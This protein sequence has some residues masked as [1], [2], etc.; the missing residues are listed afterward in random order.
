MAEE[1]NR[2]LKRI[3]FIL[4]IKKELLDEYKRE[5]AKI[6]PEMLA[7]L[8]KAGIRNYSIFLRD[9]GLMINCFETADMAQSFAI[10][11]Q[12]AVY[13]RWQN[14]MAKYFESASGDLSEGE[15]GGPLEE[16]FYLE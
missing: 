3:C 1:K 7:L 2:N 9:D 10:T 5:H 4:R 11:R 16:I 6:P 8:R 13:E 14:A 12:S 15:S